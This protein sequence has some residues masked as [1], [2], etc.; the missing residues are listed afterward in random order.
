MWGFP[1]WNSYST[2]GD[3]GSSRLLVD[4]SKKP[5]E[6]FCA[7]AAIKG[8]RDDVSGSRKGGKC[9]GVVRLSESDSALARQTDADDEWNSCDA[10]CPEV[11]HPA[12]ACS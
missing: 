6:M 11:V 3:E 10:A 2:Q 12:V 7:T 5:V 4:L 9:F 1:R 8:S